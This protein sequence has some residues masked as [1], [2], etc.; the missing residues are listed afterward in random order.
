MGAKSTVAKAR[1][2]SPSVRTTIPEAIAS[3]LK[4][5]VGDVLDWDVGMENGKKVAKLRKL[6]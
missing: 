3:D 4:L 2:D 1:T 6:E 5:R